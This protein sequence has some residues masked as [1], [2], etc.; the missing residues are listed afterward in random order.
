MPRSFAAAGVAGMSG[1]EL[2]SGPDL[3]AASS[4]LPAPAPLGIG[5][6]PV[7]VGLAVLLGVGA[8]AVPGGVGKPVTMTAGAW[9]GNDH[10]SNVDRSRLSDWRDGHALAWPP[11]LLPH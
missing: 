5:P 4:L 2:G 11:V 6:A 3:I 8:G 10:A 7:G 1:G 9:S